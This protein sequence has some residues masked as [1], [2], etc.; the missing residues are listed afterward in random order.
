[1]KTVLSYYSSTYLLGPEGD[2]HISDETLQGLGNT[3]KFLQ[4]LFRSLFGSIIDIA[5]QPPLPPPLPPEGLAAFGEDEKKDTAGQSMQML[6]PDSRVH[7]KDIQH[8]LF[9][10]SWEKVKAVLIDCA[11]NT[12]YFWVGA[13]AGIASRST[14]APLDRLKVYLIAQT[15]TNTQVV[16]GAKKG[17]PAQLLRGFWGSLANASKELWAAGGIR[18][19]FAGMYSKRP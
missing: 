14:T 11:P 17:S 8:L 19:L 15:G 6:P 10:L 5:L 16:E 9:P 7:D 18:S 2:V 12:G 13:L 1:M 4:T 3:Q